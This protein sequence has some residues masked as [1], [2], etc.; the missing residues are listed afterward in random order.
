VM[1]TLD[2]FP[3]AANLLAMADQAAAR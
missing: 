2:L 3:Q 1:K